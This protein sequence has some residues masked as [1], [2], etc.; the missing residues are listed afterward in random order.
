M[1][2]IGVEQFLV[3]GQQYTISFAQNGWNPIR[4]G[5]ADVTSALQY[6]PNVKNLS[7]HLVGGVF[8]LF[9]N[10]YDVNFT[11]TGDGADALAVVV[12][13]MLEV[14]DNLETLAT[15]DFL[16]ANT[17]SGGV[18]PNSKPADSPKPSWIPSTSALWA[19]AIVAILVVFL[20]S[21]GAGILRRVVA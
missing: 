5:S 2:A 16:G 19:I 12:E 1:P 7:V 13:P 21:G 6:I 3:S 11:Y 15:F 4:A 9:A 8:G 18:D 14:L 10:Q 20:A 17:G